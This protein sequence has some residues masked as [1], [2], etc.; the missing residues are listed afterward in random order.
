MESNGGPDPVKVTL[1]NIS[2]W[3]KSEEPYIK[4]VTAYD[5]MQDD[6]LIDPDNEY[7]TELG[8]VPQSAE[9]GSISTRTMFAPYLY[10]RFAY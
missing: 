7:S 8:Q 2:E 6:I 3:M 5:H 10:G 4:G 1:L 9:K